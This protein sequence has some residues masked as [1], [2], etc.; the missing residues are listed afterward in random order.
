[1][2]VSFIAWLAKMAA[3]LLPPEPPEPGRKRSRRLP[4]K[5][6]EDAKAKDKALHMESSN[7]QPPYGRK[8]KRPE[9]K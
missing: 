8:V 5:T 3:Y 7:G 2:E 4:V 6:K 9:T 1:M